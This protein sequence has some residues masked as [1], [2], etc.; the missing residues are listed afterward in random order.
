M[1]RIKYVPEGQ[2]VEAE[3]LFSEHKKFGALTLARRC[4]DHDPK[5]RVKAV[6]LSALEFNPA[7]GAEV[8]AKPERATAPP[9]P[10][11]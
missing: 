5:A 7:L 11:E 6:E 4:E 3:K 10:L 1:V 2:N 9:K 8:F